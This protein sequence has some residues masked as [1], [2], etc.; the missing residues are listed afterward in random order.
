LLI[1]FL[2]FLPLAAAAAK[3]KL[4]KPEA[5]APSVKTEV[6]LETAFGT[7]GGA[8]DWTLSKREPRLQGGLEAFVPLGTTDEVGLLFVGSGEARAG[9][10][11]PSGSRAFLAV[12]RAQG[13]WLTGVRWDGGPVRLDLVAGA[14]LVTDLASSDRL[15]PVTADP[16]DFWTVLV[17]RWGASASAKGD[18]GP[19]AWKLGGSVLGGKIAE[20]A[21]D[22]RWND[23]LD[24][25]AAA[26][27]GLV[28]SAG[29]HHFRLGL[30][31]QASWSSGVVS[32][33]WKDQ[34]AVEAR[35]EIGKSATLTLNPVTASGEAQDRGAWDRIW[36]TG[37]EAEVGSGGRSVRWSV[38]AGWLPSA[39][40]KT[41]LS[42]KEEY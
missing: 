28:W 12:T 24:A 31:G 42:W 14:D 33:V 11:D 18:L 38:E 1:P 23:V 19:T 17:P 34:E 9:V 13:Q 8:L 25:E 30:T 36:G 6:S 35:W 5:A 39:T 20:T 22:R 29:F 32:E 41:T 16:A 27:W 26:R 37:F 15:R 3:D 4:P 7:T 21:W 10:K 2:L 40:L